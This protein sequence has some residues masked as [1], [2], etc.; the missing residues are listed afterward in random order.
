MM[1]K[2]ISI[3]IVIAIAAAGIYWVSTFGP[4]CD[5]YVNGKCQDF[6]KRYKFEEKLTVRDNYNGNWQ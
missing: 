3:A 5:R 1:A 4:G 2:V 6:S